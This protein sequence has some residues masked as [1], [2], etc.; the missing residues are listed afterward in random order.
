LIVT[1]LAVP[2]EPISSVRPA[3]ITAPSMT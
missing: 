2:A 1:P 3:L